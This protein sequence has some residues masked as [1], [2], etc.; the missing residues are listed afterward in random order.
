MN[1]ELDHSWS[2]AT[3][4]ITCT[5]VPLVCPYYTLRVAK[6]N[7]TGAI[8]SQSMSHT[9]IRALRQNANYQSENCIQNCAI[10]MSKCMRQSYRIGKSSRIIQNQD[11]QKHFTKIHARRFLAQNP[12]ANTIYASYKCSVFG[13]AMLLPERTR[14]YNVQF[15]RIKRN[16]KLALS[17]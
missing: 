6:K 17:L 14:M 5:D 15:L 12:S 13:L 8:T 16:E 11:R 3:V 10:A 7:S 9:I 2:S 1:C 4:Q